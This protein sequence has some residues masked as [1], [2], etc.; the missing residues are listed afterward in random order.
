VC[1]GILCEIAGVLGVSIPELARRAA[2]RFE[3]LRTLSDENIQLDQR[4]LDHLADFLLM[5]AD[6]LSALAKRVRR[7]SREALERRMGVSMLTD[8]DY[9]RAS[10]LWDTM[11]LHGCFSSKWFGELDELLARASSEQIHE[12]TYGDNRE[13]LRRVLAISDWREPEG[14][15]LDDVIARLPQVPADPSSPPCPCD[16]VSRDGEGV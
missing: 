12:I 2:L 7:K 3:R 8:H 4:E 10:C 5:R 15:G 6:H 11:N 16:G 9:D 13:G 1:S 14:A